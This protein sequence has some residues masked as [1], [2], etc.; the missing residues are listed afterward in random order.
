M[1]G[2]SRIKDT[3]PTV[4]KVRGLSKKVKE[5]HPKALKVIKATSTATHKATVKA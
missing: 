4:I 3:T 1:M 5:I 2:S